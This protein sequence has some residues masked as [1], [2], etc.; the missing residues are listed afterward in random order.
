VNELTANCKHVFLDIVGYS[1]N[2]TVEAQVQIIEKLNNIVIRCLEIL[3]IRPGKVILLPTGDG[4]CISF[5]N[6]SNY[7]IHIKFALQLLFYIKLYN[8]ETEDE[9]KRFN[10]RIGINENIDNIVVDINK[11][12]NIAGSGI[13]YA[14]R[15]MSIADDNMIIVGRSVYEQINKRDKYFGKFNNW[16]TNI[17]HGEILEAYQYIE[18]TV[19]YLN[20]EIPYLFRPE[21]KEEQ[22]VNITNIFAIYLVLIKKGVEIIGNLIKDV[23]DNEYVF[24]MLYYLSD[25]VNDYFQNS[26]NLIKRYSSNYLNAISNNGKQI[27]LSNAFKGIKSKINDGL[28]VGDLFAYL[29]IKLIKQNFA[30]CLFDN[31]HLPFILSEKGIKIVETY[32]REQM[33]FIE[34]IE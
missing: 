9:K 17:K 24:V 30:E 34:T 7:E 28:M 4:M 26:K 15:L 29:R 25:Y 10:I 1:K 27:N 2:R 6:N 3:A 33:D 32:C 14:Q 11:K 20:C 31:E 22:K 8:N 21:K 16:R 12:K 13:N 19:D 5:I 18:K 23:D